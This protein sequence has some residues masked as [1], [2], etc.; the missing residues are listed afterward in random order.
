[1][2]TVYDWQPLGLLRPNFEANVAA[3]AT[4]NP[5]LAEQLRSHQPSSD[6]FLSTATG[7]LILARR[8]G[9]ELQPVQNAVN[10]PTAAAT[11]RQAFPGGACNAPMMVAGI[12]QGW[13]WNALFQLPCA[14]PGIVGLRPP[15]YLLTAEIERLWTVL[16]V[17]TWQQPLADPRTLL[18]VGPDALDQARQFMQRESMVPW[19]EFCITVEPAIFPP[20]ESFDTLTQQIREHGSQ[21]II[22]A[23]KHADAHYAGC[24][25]RAIAGQFASGKPLRVLGITSRFTTFL[26][27]SMR[28]WLDAFQRLGHETHL[29]IEHADHQV[30][31]NLVYA[32][33]T[34][35]FKPDLIL[36]IDHYRAEFTGLPTQVPCVMWVQDQLSHLCCPQAGADQGPTDYCL[37][38]GRL[39]HTRRHGYPANRYMPAVVGVN[40]RRFA[41]GPLT[42]EEQRR[43]TCDVSFVSHASTPADALVREQ[44][45]DRDPLSQRLLRDTFDQLRAVY[46]AGGCVTQPVLIRRMIETS[47]AQ[48][49]SSLD[50]PSMHSLLDFFTQKVNNALFRHQSLRWLA[51]MDINLHL[52]GRGWENHPALKRFARGIADNQADLCAIYRASRINL[53]ATPFGAVHQRLLDG[54]AAGGFFLIRHVPG[55][56]LEVIWRN[57][58]DWCCAQGITCDQ[59]ILERATPQVRQWLDQAQQ[60]MQIRLDEHE[61]KLYD[62]LELSADGGYIRSAAAVWDEYH[63]VAYRT[64]DELRQRVAHFLANDTE[65]RAIADAM[66]KPVLERFT[67]LATTRQLLR[68]IADD[69]RR[70]ST[71]REAA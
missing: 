58:W 10:P 59:Q 40:D 42:G 9:Q 69:Q 24:D 31:S 37:G 14:V 19:P 44:L 63:A 39:M 62:A 7:R 4:H 46:D 1:M 49:R 28:D 11:I 66:R 8:T 56:E 13:V 61:F 57:V 30:L 60:L 33:T 17:Q 45:K 27:H 67:Y 22:T 47:L 64:A 68:F 21:R 52:Y 26:Q 2:S 43:F 29:L 48:A 23:L 35:S 20:G 12:D 71:L 5:T 3:L 6:Y 70:A 54:L 51:E 65:R 25:A 18:F 41:P 32:Q 50:E 38:Y 53:Q 34:R 16:H 15:L 36:L 55:D